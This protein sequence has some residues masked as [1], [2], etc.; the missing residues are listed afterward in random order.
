M[1]IVQLISGRAGIGTQLFSNFRSRTCSHCATLNCNEGPGAVAHACNPST[2]GGLGGWIT[3]NSPASASRA[4]A[5]GKRHHA[6]LIFVLSEETGFHH[7]FGRPR[8]EDHLKLGVQ[9]QLDQHGETLSL[10][11]IQNYL[12]MVAY[13]CIGTLLLAKS[14]PADMPAPTIYGSL[15]WMSGPGLAH[16]L[17]E[18]E[19]GGS[20]GQEFETSLAYM[21]KP[22]SLPKIQ[23]SA[24]CSGGTCSPS[25]SGG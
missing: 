8:R 10:L 2:L 12:G 24:R 1:K 15:D 21:V 5:A 14:P 23:K 13:A 20:Q 4:E 18:A 22:P 7:H 6:Q 19:A 25:Y 3:S 11:K 16:A 17:W 9:D